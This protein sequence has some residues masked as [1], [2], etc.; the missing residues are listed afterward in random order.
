MKIVTDYVGEVE[1]T[2]D[3]VISFPDGIF[4]FEEHREFIMVGELSK[5]F[6]FVW[7]QSTKE[8]N[9]VFVLTDPFLFVED[10]DFSLEEDSVKKLGINS[11]EDLEVFGICVVPSQIKDTTLN[12]RSPIIINANKRIGLQI[13]LEE[14]WAYKHPLFKTK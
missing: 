13:I 12:L 8:E 10:Y 2:Q 14:D 3:E 9:V 6:P 5:E 11:A 7:L 1:Y 4:G